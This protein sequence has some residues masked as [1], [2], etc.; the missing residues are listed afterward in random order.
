MNQLHCTAMIRLQNMTHGQM[1]T[2][3]YLYLRIIFYEYKIM[4]M[5]DKNNCQG[6]ESVGLVSASWSEERRSPGGQPGPGT[7]DCCCDRPRENMARVTIY[8]NVIII[9]K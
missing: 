7:C 9:N 2:A 8:S 3:F 1:D 5:H 4:R 6:W